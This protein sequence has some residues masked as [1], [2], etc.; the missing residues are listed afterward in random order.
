MK[1][2][3]I[4]IIILTLFC[5]L[6]SAEAREKKSPIVR[7]DDGSVEVDGISYY[8][9]EAYLESDAF[10]LSGRRCGTA[11]PTAE[12]LQGKTASTSDCTTTLTQIQSEYDLTT[13]LVIPVYWHVIYASDGTGNISEQRIRDQIE[14]LNEDYRAMAGTDGSN[15]HDT[16]IQFQLIAI[17][18]TQNDTWFNDNDEAGYKAALKQD[19]DTFMNIYSNT[20][21]GYL[22]YAYFPQ[23]NAGDNLDG[24]VMNHEAVGGRN[25]GYSSY[26]QGRTLVHEAGHYLGLYHTFEGGGCFTGFNAGDLINDT[27]SENTAHYNC[28]QTNTCST[29]DSIHNYM[30]YTPD[31]CMN[32]FTAQQGNRMVCSLINYRPNLYSVAEVTYSPSGALML[33]LH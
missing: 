9:R 5:L 1:K 21:S 28:T 25:N 22:G 11:K 8:S 4:Y 14:V 10:K 12:E 27:N 29:P 17:T 15:G 30:N 16:M 33:L 26:D 19:P 23:T 31:S 18:R 24:V 3:S 2:T 20:A 7:Q 32:Q 13:A 6:G